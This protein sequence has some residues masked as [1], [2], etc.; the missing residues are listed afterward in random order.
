M[1]KSKRM[2]R[3]FLLTLSSALL[4]V[5]LT[6]GVTLAYLTD[7]ASVTNTF[8]VGKVEFDDG[9][10]GE[11]A[12]GIDEVKTNEYG[13]AQ[14]TTRVNGNTYKLIPGAG[15]TKDPTVHVGP[16]SEDAWLFVKVKND[17]HVL[18]P[19]DYPDDPDTPDDEFMA[20][21]IHGSMISL[22]GWELISGDANEGVYA[23]NEVVKANQDVKVFEDFFIDGSL[24]EEEIKP[25]ADKAITIDAYLVQKAG[26]GDPDTAWNHTFGKK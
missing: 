13:V 12:Y 24:S 5:S 1:K 20:Q 15:Y 11:S 2:M 16:E 4:L 8:T 21:T 22:Y 6:V 17:I 14:G 19:E 25:Y 9:G 3:K 7:T 18:E 26:F 23:Y 10:E